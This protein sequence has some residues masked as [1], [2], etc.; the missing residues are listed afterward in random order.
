MCSVLLEC[1]G[2]TFRIMK[3]DIKA[4][5][6]GPLI[7]VPIPSKG[8]WRF[9]DHPSGFSWISKGLGPEREVACRFDHRTVVEQPKVLVR[10][11]WAGAA[12][13]TMLEVYDLPPSGA[14]TRRAGK[15]WVISI[16]EVVDHVGPSSRMT[17]RR[18]RKRVSSAGREGLLVVDRRRGIAVI[19]TQAMR[20]L[21]GIPLGWGRG[22]ARVCATNLWE[23][24]MYPVSNAL[25]RIGEEEG[26]SWLRHT[27][28]NLPDDKLVHADRAF[29]QATKRLRRR[30]SAAG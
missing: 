27:T 17:L 18:V 14:V 22:R 30:L 3:V 10:R 13:A 15:N 19:V 2:E 23:Q 29:H 24:V 7:V 26:S 25:A 28:N 11:L 12:E 5:E 6:Q 20:A 21:V 1:G 16:D 9:T 4:E 8:G